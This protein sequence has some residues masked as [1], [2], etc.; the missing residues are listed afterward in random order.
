MMKGKHTSREATK[1]TSGD[2]FSDFFINA[3]SEEK[4]KVFTEAARLANKDQRELV[5]KAERIAR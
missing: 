3:S 4:I 5:K 2:G 1:R